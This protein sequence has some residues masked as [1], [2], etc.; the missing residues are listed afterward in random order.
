MGEWRGILIGMAAAI[1]AFFAVSEY[2]SLPLAQSLLVALVA[3]MVV[4]WTNEALPLGIVSLLPIVLFPAFEIL[5]I[6]KTTAN[7]ANPII[8]LFLGGFMLAVATEKTGL[9]K[10]IA[11]RLLQAF[12]NT[13]RGIIASLGITASCLSMIL[14]NTTT[15][16]LLLP[17]ALSISEDRFLK[18]RFLLAVAF[19]ASIGGITTPIGSP[20]NLILLGFLDKQGMDPIGF[21]AWVAMMLPVTMMMLY[22]MVNVLSFRSGD[23]TLNAEAFHEVHFDHHQK[24][25]TW[26]LGIL[27]TL[28]FVN[29]PIKPFYSGLG[30][31]ENAILL[32][33]GML[34]F[35][36]KIGFLEWKDSK[37]IPYEI[38]FLFGAGFC[39]ASA[40]S[41]TGLAQS[42]SKALE[43]VSALPIILIVLAVATFAIFAT[44]IL[45][46]TA[47]ISILLPIVYAAVHTLDFPLEEEL[48]MI[49]ATICTSYAFMLPI[50]TPP[51]A[52]AI[53]GGDLKVSEMARFG[54]L[55]NI[56]GVL[57]VSAIALSYWKLFL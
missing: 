12:P 53:S 9:H 22:I 29:S 11:K 56:A 1:V 45:S 41:D 46:N 40:F 34:M 18:I 42:V 15:A 39:I 19:G 25:L 8:Y 43:H 32:G 13:P 44:E 54:F 16:L 48:I 4:L 57:I 17:V 23:H 20:P 33:F 28:L 7:Y 14:S 52:I 38:M 35:V 3:F 31:N 27:V 49:T 30:L 55:L 2:A 6:Q 36:P 10:I 47:L 51:N 50:A 37:K 21:A 5:S 26:I 24:R